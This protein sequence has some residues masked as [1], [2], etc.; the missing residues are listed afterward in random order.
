MD[1]KHD[2]PS[3]HASSSTVLSILS[4][5]LLSGTPSP[6]YSRLQEPLHPSPETVLPSSHSSLKSRQP[7]PQ[8]VSEQGC[9]GGGMVQLVVHAIPKPKNAPGSHSSLPAHTLPSPQ[10]AS[11]QFRHASVKSVLPSSH[12]SSSAVPEMLSSPSLSCTPSPQNSLVHDAVQPSLLCGVQTALV[13]PGRHLLP[14]RQSKSFVQLFQVPLQCWNVGQPEDVVQEDPFE[15]RPPLSH[16]SFA[17]FVPS[18][19]I[20]FRHAAEHPSPSRGRHT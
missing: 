4:G 2:P 15:H 19:H 12:C 11:R 16:S 14:R 1:T 20:S 7:L 17:C 8:I 13:F 3:S 10:N 5:P 6:Q 18:P 9:G